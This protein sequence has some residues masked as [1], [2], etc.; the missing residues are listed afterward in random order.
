[1]RVAYLRGTEPERFWP[2]VAEV[3]TC[4]LWLAA[5]NDD[6]Y[7]I[8]RRADGTNVRA[9]RWA[10]EA[11]VGPCPEGLEP[12]HL[13]RNP[14]CVNPAHLEWVTHQENNRRGQPGRR[15][16]RRERTHCKH[17]HEFTDETTY[18]LPSTGERRCR[19]CRND[20]DRRRRQRT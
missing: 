1:M 4:W 17:G 6:G 13:C 8:F 11:I 2:K 18:V 14:A 10:W 16:W 9:H 7:G 12:D 15:V 19:P 3:G 20:S 5:T